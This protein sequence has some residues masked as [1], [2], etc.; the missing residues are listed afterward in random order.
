VRVKAK[1]RVTEVTDLAGTPHAELAARCPEQ[2]PSL[3]SDP[4]PN[5]SCP[6]RVNGP[7]YMNCSFVIFE[8]VAQTRQMLTLSEIG[9]MLGITREGVRQIEKKAL[10]RVRRRMIAA[11]MLEPRQR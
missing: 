6:W 2:R 10:L 11:E 9:T 5:E 4:C 7:S 3:P 8:A 1:P